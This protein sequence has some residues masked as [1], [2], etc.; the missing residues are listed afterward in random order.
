[1]R[2]TNEHRTILTFITAYI[3]PKT[4]AILP[5]KEKAINPHLYYIVFSD[6]LKLIFLVSCDMS[7]A[8]FLD[9]MQS[10]YFMVAYFKRIIYGVMY[11]IYSCLIVW[12]ASAN[13]LTLS[14]SAV[15]RNAGSWSW[16][17]F[18]SPAYMNSKMAV[19]CWNG[20]SFKI[21]IG[22]L[23]GFSSRRALKYGEHAD[24]TI[25]CALHVCPSQASVTSVNDFSS[26]R[27]L[28]EETMFVWKSFQRRQ[29]CCWSP[30]CAIFVF[31]RY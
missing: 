17:T 7:F 3:W 30:A 31:V 6:D 28:K 25:L 1:M 8:Q 16:A 26:R 23:A 10:R 2:K 24:R 13:P 5:Y 29:N 11:E 14:R 22:C 12:G 19:R 15:F 4:I 20:T 21:M 9:K 18:T 27:C